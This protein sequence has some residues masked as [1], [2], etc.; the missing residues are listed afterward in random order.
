[1]RRGREVTDTTRYKRTLDSCLKNYIAV[2]N[3]AEKPLPEDAKER[4]ADDSYHQGIRKQLSVS[5]DICR[6]WTKSNNKFDCVFMD[7]YK[8]SLLHFKTEPKT[9]APFPT[10][11]K[12]RYLTKAIESTNSARNIWQHLT[13]TALVDAGHTASERRAALTLEMVRW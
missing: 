6:Q 8:A 12:Q 13:E 4:L 9:E 2:I 1:M 11:L 5:L 7:I 10:W 3:T